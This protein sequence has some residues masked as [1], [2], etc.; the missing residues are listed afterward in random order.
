M[1]GSLY[2]VADFYRVS[3][4]GYHLWYRMECRLTRTVHESVLR[5][6][7]PLLRRVR[8]ILSLSTLPPPGSF[9]FFK[10]L[11]VAIAMSI[12]RDDMGNIREMHTTAGL[13]HNFRDASGGT[14]GRQLYVNSFGSQLI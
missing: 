9:V 1:A 6:T 2:L 7:A 14:D 4:A 8:T 13:P 10:S 12:A 11:L 5:V 3:V